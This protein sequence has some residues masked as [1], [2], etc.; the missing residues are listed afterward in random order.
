[1]SKPPVHDRKGKVVGSGVHP[2]YFSHLSPLKDVD[3][4]MP[5]LIGERIEVEPHNPISSNDIIS[6]MIKKG[7]NVAQVPLAVYS[8]RSEGVP[9]KMDNSDVIAGYEPLYDDLGHFDEIR[10]DLIGVK[11]IISQSVESSDLISSMCHQDLDKWCMQRWRPPGWFLH[12]PFSPDLKL[13]GYA[14]SFH[15]TLDVVTDVYASKV[16]KEIA[17]LSMKD[18]MMMDFDP[19]DTNVGMPTLAS[20]DMTHQARVAILLALPPPSGNPRQWLDAYDAIGRSFGMPDHFIYSSTLAT[21]HGPTKKPIELYVADAF[22]YTSKYSSVGLYDRTRFVYP[23]PYPLNFILSAAYIQLKEAR[24]RILGLWHDDDSVLAYIAAMK[25]QGKY[26][27]SMDFSGMDTTMPPHLIKLLC[28]SLISKGFIRWPLEL[29][30]LV[31]DRMGVIMP[32]FSGQFSE[33]TYVTR[34]ISWLS[35]FKLTSEMDTLFGCCTLLT[36]LATVHDSGI[37]EKWKNGRFVFAELGDDIVFVLDKPLDTEAA[38]DCAKK[39]CGA[40]LKIMEDAMFL[41]RML[42]LHPDIPKLTKPFSRFGQQNFL[43]ED[44]YSGTVGGTR[45]PAVM[46]LSLAARF[47]TLDNHPFFD[48]IWPSMADIVLK[49]GYVRDASDKYKANLRK[50]IVGLDAGDETEIQLYATRNPDFLVK[51]ADRAKFEPSTAALLQLMHSI[52]IKEQVDVN[53]MTIRSLYMKSLLT[54]TASHHISELRKLCSWLD[55]SSDV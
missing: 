43:N 24:T 3:K 6:A 34:I 31:I 46:R 11:D 25:K 29:L 21:R 54:P 42:P 9:R 8:K 2:D 7:A 37:R 19:N 27:Y 36:V 53:V 33:S 39:I 20:G 18:L 40:D 5:A 44:R 45:P 14:L 51:L 28:G 38:A 13:D 32:S 10:R 4:I 48:R 52:G 16:P 41:K 47:L 17:Q 35:G 23:I 1:M 50:G 30:S 22:G 12:M 26:V 15:R 49:L 55:R